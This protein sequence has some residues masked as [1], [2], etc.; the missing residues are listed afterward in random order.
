MATFNVAI[1]HKST[2]EDVYIGYHIPKGS[3][4]YLNVVYVLVFPAQCGFTL[5]ATHYHSFMLNNPN[6]W[7]HLQSFKPEHFLNELIPDKLKLKGAIFGF[8]LQLVPH[9]IH[10]TGACS[11]SEFVLGNV[12]DNT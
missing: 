1:L 12:L 10:S 11:D 2:E 4:I 6:V 8:V 7:P 5:I 3:I 9:P